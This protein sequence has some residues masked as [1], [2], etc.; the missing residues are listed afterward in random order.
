MR[1]IRFTNKICSGVEVWMDAHRY[2]IIEACAGPRPVKRRIVPL[3]LGR[4]L[5]RHA[6]RIP[7]YRFD[8]LRD[9]RRF[10]EY[11]LRTGSS[12][13]AAHNVLARLPEFHGMDAPGPGQ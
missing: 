5:G 1:N 4:T 10:C 13:W 8:T 11:W 6:D 9:A 3:G 7:I 12:R 2:A